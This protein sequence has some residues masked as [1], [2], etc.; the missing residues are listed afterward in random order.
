VQSSTVL[1]P[2]SSE[3]ARPKRRAALHFRTLRSFRIFG[4]PGSLLQ[5]RTADLG[6]LLSALSDAQQCAPGQAVHVI[7][8]ATVSVFVIA[9][10]R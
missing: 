2:V 10:L 6:H 7:V 1:I 4:Y 3:G 9:A 8:R 5:Q